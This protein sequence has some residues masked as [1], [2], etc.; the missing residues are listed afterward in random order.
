M[1]LCICCAG[2]VVYMWYCIDVMHMVLVYM[3]Y[4]VHVVHAVL[5]AC[6]TMYVHGVVMVS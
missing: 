4:C 1:M 5:R 2:S 3:W 6:G